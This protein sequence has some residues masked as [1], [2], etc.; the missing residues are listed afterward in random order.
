MYLA[1]R[2][3]VLAAAAGLTRGARRQARADMGRKFSGPTVN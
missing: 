2:R 3:V 1:V